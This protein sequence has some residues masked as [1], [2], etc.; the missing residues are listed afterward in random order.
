ML[1]PLRFHPLFRR[2]IWGGRRL[3]TALGK[4]IGP[5][6]DYAESWEIV[7][8]PHDQSVVAN[9]SLAGQTLRQIMQQ[10]QAAIMGRHEDLERFPLLLKFLDCNTNLSVQVHP[11]DA[12]AALLTPPDLGKTEAW[13]VI[14]AGP[15]GQIYAG[16]KAGVDRD[17][18]AEHIAAGSLESDLHVF[19]PAVG[20]CIFIPAGVVHALG[21]GL[22]IAEI[23][24]CSDTT[25]RLYD[26]GRVDADGV[27][28]QLHIAEALACID[29]QRGPVMPS[30][31]VETAQQFRQSLV[32]CDKFLLDRL[33]VRDAVTIAGDDTPHLLAVLSGI[34]QVEGDPASEAIRTGRTML[35]P[36]ACGTTRLVPSEPSV[37]LDI[38]LP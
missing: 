35:L 1:Y 19:E 27:S 6:D 21:A 24:Q 12:Q 13:V 15:G 33:N 38:Y 4:D 10:H 37:V 7:D 34:I 20:D 28:R 30:A 17:T 11:N 5:G 31:P 8:R 18:L 32:N 25:Y 2:Y 36:A 16:L 9:G 3:Q 23:Q 14:E 29:Y 26:W 22:V